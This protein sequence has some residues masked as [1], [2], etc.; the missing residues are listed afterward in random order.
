MN[1]FHFT[2]RAADPLTDFGATAARFLPLLE[3][4]GNSHVSC[5]HLD[6]NA[7]IA[8]PSLTHAAAL[9]C[10]RGRITVTTRD[11]RMRIE[12]HAGMGCV[13]DA[14]EPYAIESATGAIVIII[15]AD[16]LAAHERGISTPARIAGAAWPGDNLAV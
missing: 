11:P 5:L 12:I 14:G 1:V 7:T 2:E 9:L 6:S 8:S 15:E 3:G 4:Q 16:S 10:V 13:L